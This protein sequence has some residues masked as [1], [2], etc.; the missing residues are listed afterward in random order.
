M[1]SLVIPNI[2]WYA[3]E[4][5]ADT[6][7]PDD[8]PDVR[9][10]LADGYEIAAHCVPDYDNAQLV[11]RGRYEAQVWMPPGSYLWGVAGSSSSS[12]GFRCQVIDAG[13]QAPL[14]SARAQHP[15]VTGGALLSQPY[16][17]HVL[18][19]PRLVLEP[20]V[21]IVQIENLASVAADIQFV[22]Y[23]AEPLGG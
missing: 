14:F 8:W 11:A 15:A 4:V 3:A 7:W 5:G 9:H 23:T 16:P 21:L 20:G 13:T 18:H 1:E 6:P 10:L 22:L 17:I 2:A 19:R 12:D